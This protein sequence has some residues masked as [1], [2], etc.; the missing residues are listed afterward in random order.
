MDARKLLQLSKKLLTRR[1]R[2]RAGTVRRVRPS[3]Q[4]LEPMILPN[5][6]VASGAGP[7]APPM[8]RVY[9]A[10]TGKLIRQFVAY[11][12]TFTGGVNVAVADLNGDGK[13]DIVTGAGEGGGPHV[14]VFDGATGTRLVDF[15][16]YD[17]SLR[18]GVAV[19]AGTF[20]GVGCI[21]TGAGPGGGPHVKVF[22][23]TGDMQWSVMAFGVNFRGGVHI[24]VGQV[25]SLSGPSVIVGAGETGGPHV[26]VYNGTTHALVRDFMAFDPAFRG[27]V[28][29]AVGDLNGDGVGEIVT[30]AGSGGGPQVKV[31]HGNSGAVQQ[32]FFAGAVTLRG[33]VA[34]GAA[35]LRNRPGNAADIVA[36][37]GGVSPGMAV[38]LDGATGLPVGG[39]FGQFQAPP[40]GPDGGTSVGT[41]NLTEPADPCP[42]EDSFPWTPYGPRAVCDIDQGAPEFPQPDLIEGDWG[43]PGQAAPDM[44]PS[45]VRY[46]DGAALLPQFDLVS[47][48]PFGPWG[49]T[50]SWTNKFDYDRGSYNG[51]GW[52]TPN[53]PSLIE[54]WYPPPP[55]GEPRFAVVSNGTTATVFDGF[56]PRDFSQ[57]TLAVDPT[58]S[59]RYVFTDPTGA[60][61]RFWYFPHD[62]DDPDVPDVKKGQFYSYTDPGG[63]ET[64]VHE[65]WPDGKV[66][67]VRRSG[68]INGTSVTEDYTYT[69]EPTTEH[70][71]P[72]IASVKLTRNGVDVRSV[73]YAYYVDPSDLNGNPEDLKTATVKDLTVA[74]QPVIDTYYYRYYTAGDTGGYMHGLKY[75]LGPAA[76]ERLAHDYPGDPTQAS[77]V[78]AYADH[79]FTYDGNQ[80]V[81]DHFVQG[82]GCAT[83]TGGPGLYHY[84]YTDNPDSNYS[85]GYNSWKTKTVETL[86]GTLQRRNI[87]YSNY[88]HEVMLSAYRDGP[89]DS[90]TLK[91]WKTY[92]R[93][94]E[95]GRLSFTAMPSAVNTY[96]DAFADL[97][98]FDEPTGNYGG[99]FDNSGLIVTTTYNSIG[100]QEYTKL[101]HGDLDPE[102]D[103]L[104]RLQ[105]QT[106]TDTVTGAVVH[107]VSESTVYN[108]D[109]QTTTYTYEAWY[110]HNTG[111]FNQPQRIKTTLPVVW[112]WQN[113]P[114]PAGARDESSVAYDTVGRPIWTKDGDGFLTYTEYS[115]ATG[116]VV[117]TITDVDTNV[118]GDFVG[119]AP[120]THVG[121]MRLT[122]RMAVDGLGR[123][124]KVTAPNGT[125]HYTVYNDVA[126]EVRDYD[127][128]PTPTSPRPIGPIT[129]TRENRF[130]Q[131]NYTETFTFIV[132]DPN[133]SWQST[134][135]TGNEP[136]APGSVKSLSRSIRNDFGQT[137]AFDQYF[138]LDGVTYDPDLLQLGTAWDPSNP[139]AGNF[140]HTEY[141]YDDNS[142]L[143]RTLSPTRTITRTVYDSRMRPASTWVGTNDGADPNAWSPDN[144]GAPSNMVKV[145]QNEYD[146]GV[147]GDGNRTAFAEY[148]AA[149]LSPSYINDRVTVYAYDWRNRLVTTKVGNEAIEPSENTDV[150]RPVFYTEYDNLSRVVASE[151]YDGDR[152]FIYADTNNDGVPDRPAVSPLTAKTTTSYDDQ[153]RPYLV[154]VLGV[155]TSG[156]SL[157][158]FTNTWYNHRGQVAKVSAPGGVVTKYEY[159][160]AGRV[161]KTY[162]TDGKNDSTW[163][164]AVAVSDD[165]VLEQVETEYDPNGNVTLTRI[166]QR[167]DDETLP[168]G[169][170]NPSTGVRARV[171]YVATYYD[172]ANRPTHTVNVGTNQGAIWNRPPQPPSPSNT[173]LVTNTAYDDAGRPATITDPL[174]LIT[175]L[176]YDLM[177]RTKTKIEHFVNGPPP[178][179]PPDSDNKTTR[180]A[181]WGPNLTRTITADLVGGSETTQY[182]YGVGG[183]A[184]APIS[185]N[186]LLLRV[187][188]PDKTT[189]APNP[190]DFEQF[191][192][193]TSGAVFT[194]RDRNNTTHLYNYDV[195]GRQTADRAIGSNFDG[196]VKRHET[197][198][199][200][201]GRPYLFTSYNDALYGTVVNQVQR[202][203]NGAGQVVAEYQSHSGAVDFGNTNATLQVYYSYT[204]QAGGSRLTGVTYP[205][206]TGVQY[207][208]TSDVDNRISRVTSLQTVAGA[209]SPTV[210]SYSYLGLGTVVQR[211]HPQS[212]VD[213]T[214]IGV[215][216][217]DAGDKYVGLDRFGRV[218]DQRWKSS[219]PDVDHFG[220]GYDRDSNRTYRENLLSSPAGGDKSELY[221]Y[222]GLNQLR[223]FGRGTLNGT[224][225]GF[226]AGPAHSQEWTHDAAGNFKSVKTDSQAPVTRDHNKQNQATVVGGATLAYDAKGNLTTDETARTF[227]Y[228][229]WNHV[230]K[231]NGTTRYAYDALG[232][233][234]KEGST[235]LYYDTDWRLIAEGPPNTHYSSAH[236]VWSPVYVDEMVLRDRDTNNN[237]GDGLEERLYPLSDANHNV[238]ALVNTS[239]SVVE[240]YLYDPYGRFDVKD[241]SWAD[242]PSSSYAWV[243]L[244]QGGRYDSTA[245]TYHFRNRD[246]SP[247]LGRFIS[248]DPL[249]FDAGDVNFYRYVGDDPTSRTDPI[250]L[251]D[252]YRENFVRETPDMPLDWRVHH[253]RQRALTER[254]KSMGID[255]NELSSLRAV[256][257]SVHDDINWLQREWS[258]AEMKAMGLIRPDAR[259][260]DPK[261]WERFW[262]NVDMKKVKEFEDQLEQIY[263]H[264][265][266]KVRGTASE[267]AS[268]RRLT[269]STVQES[270]RRAQLGNNLRTLS[271]RLGKA[272]VI[273]GIFESLGT[274]ASF[275]NATRTHTWEQQR[276]WDEFFRMHNHLLE[277][278]VS[279]SMLTK[280]DAHHL[281][282]A[283]L[284]YVHSINDNDDMIN[285]IGA[286][287]GT[288]IDLHLN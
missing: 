159:D 187:L 91:E 257:R 98:A 1:F 110:P 63:N 245:G 217:A 118:P 168:G 85:D 40:S 132:T 39:P 171:S 242:R 191:N 175:L 183:S 169:L 54:R 133:Y 219:G 56:Q 47:G 101:Q 260:A 207:N 88:R 232:R 270:M 286:A 160:G 236:Y 163:D 268:V 24:A 74:Q 265:W 35:Q 95:Q 147:I 197:A 172:N 262:K 27:G 211:S 186:D 180:Y 42:I 222:D 127:W 125:V 195:A 90:P 230:I 65:E 38:L 106:H 120:W 213:L 92:Y 9:D 280:Q 22:D 93:Y 69:Y 288:W 134:G 26:R 121:G 273:F 59:H 122:T 221:T 220:Y 214:Y 244:H 267:F 218:V 266:V 28:N 279:G 173:V 5:A 271:S 145:S 48:G 108:P 189:G 157:S 46:S 25:G 11:D 107:P 51:F 138:N 62:E 86:P 182:V 194:Y 158:L 135:P 240:R 215:G 243:Y 210:E 123:T 8:V 31:F 76:Y 255:V 253:T 100:Y 50:R 84:E 254:Y 103:L 81:I 104:S 124:T 44:S 165:N 247:T 209:N 115:P 281:K 37:P 68:M 174:G 176:E 72:R 45:G 153:N 15:M 201:A 256:P 177:G 228:D 119:Q 167:F 283:F 196:T 269:G 216:T 83:C 126:D 111:E 34:V 144:N 161:A 192:Y 148:G 32:S 154:A 206:N 78:G 12:P 150:N 212:A 179:P 285:R 128:D 77:E 99:L 61:I 178:N 23:T 13:V 237:I 263:K 75:A 275:A 10:A 170:G 7:G 105:Y 204:T 164:H 233:R 231:V 139:T 193:L 66:K 112:T 114:G 151:R 229:A 4:E 234:I 224:K 33:G 3:L 57:S 156:G 205:D 185:S 41:A 117:K 272:L 130:R 277:K 71:T 16:A 181:Y 282:D 252:P 284:R 36:L 80:R 21:V 200:S 29:V 188:Y 246:Y 18:G 87:V 190:N 141:A 73:T 258:L 52:V 82:E 184:G 238:T 142:Q 250:G 102:P 198:Y 20:N 96:N 226:T 58:N 276:L 199:D 136:I 146:R 67:V 49:H 113:G 264:Y 235:D 149:V 162:T 43:L 155:G 109:A 53:I 241:P 203:F 261:T 94:D 227:T 64:R 225:D 97:V 143:I 60:Q 249:G 6:V 223:T 129:V 70:I 278:G 166:R 17:R 2:L 30:G 137:R 259:S 274:A 79:F 248:V 116:A 131:R 208:Y 287:M 202:A 19:A 14:R 251:A 140:Y 89:D 152:A 239:G 55:E